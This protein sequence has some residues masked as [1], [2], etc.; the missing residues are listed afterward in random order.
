MAATTTLTPCWTA[1]RHGDSPLDRWKALEMAYWRTDPKWQELMKSDPAKFARQWYPALAAKQTETL[2]RAAR[3]IARM[4]TLGPA[5]PHAQRLT[6]L[7]GRFL[8]IMDD[9]LG[10]PAT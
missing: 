8:F 2:Q 1:G 9:D 4:W 5:Q 7:I 10:T 6:G 3:A